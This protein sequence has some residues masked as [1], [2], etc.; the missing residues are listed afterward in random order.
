MI[1]K[2]LCA[3]LVAALLLLPAAALA[4]SITEATMIYEDEDGFQTQQTVSDPAL[5]S[6]ADAETRRLTIESLR[7]Y[8]LTHPDSPGAADRLNSLPA[9]P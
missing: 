9:A 2:A 5:L 8:Y 6:E 7:A 1:R 4:A 3:L